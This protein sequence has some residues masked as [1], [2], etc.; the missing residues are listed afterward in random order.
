M[1]TTVCVAAG[2]LFKSSLYATASSQ[3]V[4]NVANDDRES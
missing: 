4:P 3:T 2:T 1:N